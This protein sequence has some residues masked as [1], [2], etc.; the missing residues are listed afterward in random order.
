MN[1]NFKIIAC[2]LSVLFLMGCATAKGSVILTGVARPSADPQSVKLYLKEP[3]KYD[4]IGLVEA[5]SDWGWTDQKSQDYA[6]EELKKQAAKIG[7]NGV[8]LTTT[9]TQT[10]GIVGGYGAGAMLAVPA[11]AKVVKGT[12]IFVDEE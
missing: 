8:L 12:A 3:K 7:A 1:L 2:C 5:S 11:D 4:V 6:V 10:S 9:G